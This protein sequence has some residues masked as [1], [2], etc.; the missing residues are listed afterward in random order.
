MILYDH[1]LSSYAQKVKIALREKGVAFERMLPDGFGTGRRDTDF[2][3]A[4]PRGE[5]P[6]LL[7]D[8]GMPIFESTVILEYIE[9]RW[10]GTKLCPRIRKRG[11]MRA[12]PRRCAI[13]S[14]RP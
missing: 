3:A 13:R 6:V 14:T 7:P 2:A 4:N 5:V 11:P 10:L 9:D 8:G 1:P 12:S